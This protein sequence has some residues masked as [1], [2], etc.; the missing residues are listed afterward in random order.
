MVF[1]VTETDADIV[2]CNEFMRYLGEKQSVAV[3]K[4]WGRIT[5][6]LVPPSDF[7]GQVLRLCL[8]HCRVIPKH[9]MDY[10]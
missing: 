6:F 7:S 8:V 3:A 10:Q 5:S 1:F 4:L 2:F 9:N